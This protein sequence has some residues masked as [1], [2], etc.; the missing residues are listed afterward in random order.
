[1]PTK[2]VRPLAMAVISCIACGSVNV[3]GEGAGGSGT[4]I[5]NTGTQPATTHT[6]DSI[7]KGIDQLRSLIDQR[8][9]S[10]AW[11]LAN[12]MRVVA[13]GEEDFDFYY[14]LA[15]L[16]SAYVNEAL[17]ALE[18]VVLINP[19]HHR[20]RLEMARAYFL[21]G[22]MEGAEQ[23]LD[24]VE[25]IDPPPNVQKNISRFRDKIESVKQRREWNF[26]PRVA[27]ATGSDSNINSATSEL[28]I[29]VPQLGELRLNDSSRETDD[30][31]Y[32]IDAGVGVYYPL[33]K[34]Q[35]LLMDASVSDKTFSSEDD[36]DQQIA[37]LYLAYQHQWQQQYLSVGGR[38]YETSLSGDDF[39]ESNS[40]SLGWTSQ[41]AAGSNQ[42][43][44]LYSEI[45]YP[46][47]PARDISQTVLAF[48]S[49]WNDGTLFHGITL[50][51]GFEDTLKSISNQ[52][53]SL[54]NSHNAKD[55]TG[56]MYSARW[57][58]NPDW[59][60]SIRGGYQEQEYAAR[61][62][63]FQVVREDDQVQLGMKFKWKFHKD[64]SSSFDVSYMDNNSN[65]DLY[66]YDRVTA[67][68]GIHYGF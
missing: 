14:G 13:E 66:A 6:T 12:Q 29:T 46:Q 17:F 39:Q 9:F 47:D 23:A 61:Q 28:N 51:F 37:S 25:S 55:F 49:N 5:G 44:L 22:D 33:S 50:L 21:L 65:L 64:F 45:S 27:L 34:Y 20:A 4:T 48:S 60:F 3:F 42:A 36:Y 10:Q 67:K 59:S 18:R 7:N 1:M 43:N 56:I 58:L 26:S 19:N 38:Y 62:P 2:M 57:R 40:L 41:R 30:S 63:V 16:E 35:R 68:V 31:F 53:G 24:I 8:E 52:S 15:A 32:Q 54:T 11:L